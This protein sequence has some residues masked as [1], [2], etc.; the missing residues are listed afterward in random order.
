MTFEGEHKII[1]IKGVARVGADYVCEDGAM[2]QI[3]GME[4]RDGSY[5]PYT[6]EDMGVKLPDYIEKVYTH[7]TSYSDN[8]IIIYQG[9]LL[10]ISTGDIFDGKGDSIGNWKLFYSGSDAKDVAFI[11]N[12]ITVITETGIKY[13]VFNGKSYVN[14]TYAPS[15]YSNHLLRFRVTRGIAGHDK[16]DDQIPISV[17]SL[18][19][20][21]YSDTTGYGSAIKNRWDEFVSVVNN[22]G[23]GSS[24][25]TKAQGLLTEKGGLHGYFLVCYVYRLRNGELRYAS[26]PMLM[27]PPCIKQ[28]GNYA[29]ADNDEEKGN[30]KLYKR[31]DYSSNAE[32]NP[33]TYPPNDFIGG[34]LGTG[35]SDVCAQL[36]RI[37]DNNVVY[38]M[39]EETQ[40]ESVS[41][42]AYQYIL[43]T[44]Y[45]KDA[46]FE[47]VVQSDGGSSTYKRYFYS[48]LKEKLEDGS[49]SDKVVQPIPMSSSISLW[50]KNGEQGDEA[51]KADKAYKT[52]T[53]HALSNK[54]QFGIDAYTAENLPDDVSSVC[55]FI[56]NQISP[57]SETIEDAYVDVH[58]P[59]LDGHTL[60]AKGT[61][62]SDFKMMYTYTPKYRSNELI[63]TD[64]KNLKS[65]YLVKEIYV[66]ELKSLDS[67]K[68][69]DVDLRGL[70]GDTLLTRESLPLTAFDYTT[71]SANIMKSYNYRMHMADTISKLSNGYNWLSFINDWNSGRGQWYNGDLGDNEAFVCNLGGKNHRFI[72][73]VHL[74]NSDNSESVVV[75]AIPEASK[76]YNF[77]SPYLIYPD[78]R[79]YKMDIYIYTRGGYMYMKS[80]DLIA[81]K[82]LGFSFYLDNSIKEI[83]ITTT[84]SGAINTGEQLKALES[85]TEHK[86]ENAI[87]VSDTGFPS[88]FPHINTDRVGN[89]KIIGL[90]RL[91]VAM[92]QDTYGQHPLLVFTTEGIY[93]LGVDTTGAKAYSS[94]PMFSNEVCINPKTIC[95]LSGGVLFASE[96]GLMIATENGVDFFAPMLNGPVRHAP[97][98]SNSLGVGLKW[99][100][101]MVNSDAMTQLNG[102]LSDTDF[103]DYLR[104]S[105]TSIAYVLNKNKVLVYNSSEQYCYWIDIA[106][107]L[108]TTMPINILMH[109]NDYLYNG[110]LTGDYEIVRFMDEHYESVDTLMQTRPIKLTSNLKSSIRVVLRGK[111]SS[112]SS[113]KYAVLL[114]LGS[115]DGDHWLPVGIKEKS[116]NA[117]FHNIGCVTERVSVN[118]LM[119]VFAGNLG[120]DSNIYSLELTMNNKYNNKLR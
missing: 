55:I 47:S 42:T 94:H 81:N 87:R 27:C 72:C 68:W 28:K 14:Q 74:R 110:F 115:Y 24:L 71:F 46:S 9:N 65:L 80:V 84:V 11:G 7:T 15:D 56:S 83:D 50:V 89:G 69:I 34:N 106:T 75:S 62:S 8:V 33:N 23:E 92:S 61:L 12:S 112:A 51:S 70:L 97:Q 57:F 79:A 66:E 78:T 107:R 109:N 60:T 31:D 67:T 37:D 40:Y 53:T 117:E 18:K 21:H 88:I 58:G 102:S 63:T 43:A 99:Y 119:V 41:E 5:I 77:M 114:V 85:N 20:T 98:N 118:Y 45:E 95:E 82:Y 91:T 2:N 1:P 48:L 59:F 38:G 26:A 39:F 29:N 108:A 10:F 76:N 19:C 101:N 120:N 113:N 100:Y 90:A 25:L 116:L 93:S 103:K 73:V 30:F 105:D 86:D 4:Y 104:Y 52:V 35:R 17:Q 44:E 96:K 32:K 111:F 54:L 64:I 22:K 6:Y 16:I 49:F 36:I 13:F 3:V